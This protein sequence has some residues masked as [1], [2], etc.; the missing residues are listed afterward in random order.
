MKL[1]QYVYNG[2]QAIGLLED[3]CVKIISNF[4]KDIPNSMVELLA[5]GEELLNVVKSVS[6]QSKNVISIKDVQLLPPITGCEK[7]ICVGLNYKDHCTEQNLSFPE[8]PVIFSKFP[9]AIISSGE[10]IVLPKISDSVDWEVELAVIIGKKGKN[11]N[12]NE[13]FNYVAGYTVA[14]DV[15]ARDWQLKKNANQWLLGKTFDT[16]CPLGPALVTKDSVSDPHHLNL[17]CIVNDEVMQSS[18]TKEL[19]FDI[20][21]CIEWI[22]QFCTLKPGDVILTGTPPGVGVFKKP[23]TYL[24]SGDVVKCQIDEIGEIVNKIVCEK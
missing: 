6:V 7:I 14:N 9:S 11:I 24:K 8:E 21:T 2:E 22:S 10:E 15:S 17:K 5:G 18:N 13:A 20:P 16:F 19:I 4:H 1:V 3:G 12:K 23:A